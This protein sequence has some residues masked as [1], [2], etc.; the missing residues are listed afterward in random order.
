MQLDV[1]NIR[2]NVDEQATEH[3]SLLPHSAVRTE[4]SVRK[5]AQHKIY[6]YHDKLPHWAQKACHYMHK[7]CNGASLG[8]LLGLIVGLV[9]WLHKVFFSDTQEGGYLNAWLTS[10][11]RNIGDLFVVLQ[12]VVV[13][14]Q[15]AH[16]LRK[17]KHGEESGHIPWAPMIFVLTTRYLIWPGY[18]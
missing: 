17:L 6:V 10:S 2:V 13:G 11:I 4:E 1:D 14:V 12:V 15:L 9:P 5:K 8:A 3:S 18:V 16:S 7:F